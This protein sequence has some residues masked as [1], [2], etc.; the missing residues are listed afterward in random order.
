M[1]STTKCWVP[2]HSHELENESVSSLGGM[3]GTLNRRT[4]LSKKNVRWRP[5]VCLMFPNNLIWLFIFTWHMCITFFRDTWR[6]AYIMKLVLD[7][8][9]PKSEPI[10]SAKMHAAQS[11]LSP[12][13]PTQALRSQQ[14]NGRVGITEGHSN[15]HSRRGLESVRHRPGPS[16]M[17]EY[18][19]CRVVLRTE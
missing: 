3:L 6:L 13:F 9:L 17:E 12:S 5:G 2:F 14:N 18:S 1:S 7:S 8:V 11:S 4:R 15:V 19:F 16:K 10:I